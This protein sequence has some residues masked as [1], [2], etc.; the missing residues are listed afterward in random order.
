MN[1]KHIEAI[2]RKSAL[3]V[4]NGDYTQEQLGQKL[5]AVAAEIEQLRKASERPITAETLA[6]IRVAPPGPDPLSLE[7]LGVFAPSLQPRP[8]TEP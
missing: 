3:E 4:K 7:T 1:T 2:L 5:S 6:Q 8:I